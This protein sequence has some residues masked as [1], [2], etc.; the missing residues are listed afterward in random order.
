VGE[1]QYHCEDGEGS[2][3][4]HEH[5]TPDDEAPERPDATRMLLEVSAHGLGEIGS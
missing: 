3:D 2:E 1:R 5:G 4:W